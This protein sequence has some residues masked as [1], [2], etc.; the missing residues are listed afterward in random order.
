MPADRPGAFVVRVD[1]ADQSLVDLG[2]PTRL[3]FDYVRR[4]GDVLDAWQPEGE[5]VRIVH[6]GGAG[7]TLPRYV[8]ATRP[9]SAQVVLEPDLRLTEHVREELPLPRRSGIKVRAVDGRAGTAALRAESHDLVV[10][11]AFAAARVPAELVTVEYAASAAR[12][13]APAGWL[14]MNL[15]DRA[16][17]TWT[18]R[19]VAAVRT[20]L[21]D[22][23]LSAEPA[24][25][26]GRR[27]GN[28]LLV[29]GRRGVPAAALRSRTA[30][31]G[32]P[33][34]VLAGGELDSSFGG[35]RPFTE[36]DCA[37]SPLPGDR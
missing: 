15:T 36:D 21:P 18:R 34:R 23:V 12:A 10:V 17:F 7:L 26:R 27:F 8:A 4:M 5:P 2:D 6:V 25:L 22:L 30:T 3:D 37:P 16:P 29:A 1:G 11:D 9:R 32:L 14:L 20:V 35:G 33:Y 24:T 31:S 19:V 28:L 13:L